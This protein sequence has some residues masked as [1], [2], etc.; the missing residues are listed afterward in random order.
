MKQQPLLLTQNLTVPCQQ[1]IH[2]RAAS[3]IVTLANRFRADVWFSSQSRSA[4]AKSILSMLELGAVAEEK[5]VLTAKGADAADAVKAM[6]ELFNS[7]NALCGL[8]PHTDP[9][10]K[11]S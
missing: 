5:L 4:N 3:Q 9:P 8:S 11:R 2:M 1:G 6:T 10:L 7:Q